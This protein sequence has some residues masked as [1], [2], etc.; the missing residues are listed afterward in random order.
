MTG[1]GLTYKLWELVHL[2]DCQCKSDDLLQRSGRRRRRTRRLGTTHRR[3]Q[4]TSFLVGKQYLRIEYVS[5]FFSVFFCYWGYSIPFLFGTNGQAIIVRNDL[6]RRV[7]R[8]IGNHWNWNA[9]HL[10][11]HHKLLDYCA[12]Q[13]TN[14]LYTLPKQP[15]L[16]GFPVALLVLLTA[17]PYA[18]AATATEKSIHRSACN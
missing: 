14:I 2:N 10:E 1:V 12:A 11:Q 17:V 3:N 8:S 7:V 5:V 9:D 6:H 15:N 16:V 13:Q 18:T 4:A